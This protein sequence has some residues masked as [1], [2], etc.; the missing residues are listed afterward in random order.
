M[1]DIA[2]VKAYLAAIG[3]P[4][5][6]YS[7]AVLD[8]ALTVETQLQET[9]CRTLAN[10]PTGISPSDL[11]VLDHALCRRVQ[12]N[13]AKRALSLGMTEASGDA[14]GGRVFLPKIDPEVRRLE[15][16]YRK[17]VCG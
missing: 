16:P 8:E 15:A 13:L 17:L 6:R 7:D 10:D 2:D 14:E 4:T 9:R 12:V 3:V 1:A 11:A 5:G